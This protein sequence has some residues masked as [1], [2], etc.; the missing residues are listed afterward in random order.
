MDGSM[1]PGDAP[2][3]EQS[4]LDRYRAIALTSREMVAAARAEDWERVQALERECLQQVLHLKRAAQVQSLSAPDQATRVHLLRSVLA[5][6]AEIRR[7]AEPWL[8]QLEHLLLPP[9]RKRARG[10]KRGGT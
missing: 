1:Q 10:A 8:A 6:D 4:L 2:R 7:L 9:L 3:Q 5:D